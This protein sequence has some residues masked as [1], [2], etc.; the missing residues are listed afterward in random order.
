MIKMEIKL[1]CDEKVAYSSP[2]HITPIG[3]MQDSSK[4]P[5][6]NRKIYKLFSKTK[7]NLRFVSVVKNNS[8]NLTR[9][10]N[11]AIKYGKKQSIVALSVETLIVKIGIIYQ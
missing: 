4:N 1:D 5:R 10:I 8:L 2:D 7:N 3:T 11:Q 9:S 6:F